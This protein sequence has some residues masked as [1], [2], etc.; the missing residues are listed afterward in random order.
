LKKEGE[1]ISFGSSSRSASGMKNR[2]TMKKS[3]YEDI[4]KAVL[5]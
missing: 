2:K 4:D 3:S 5:V 1:W